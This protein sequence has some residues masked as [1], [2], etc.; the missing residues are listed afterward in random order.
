VT[1][2]LP[3]SLLSASLARSMMKGR[4]TR[5]LPI[6]LIDRFVFGI[7]PSSRASGSMMAATLLARNLTRKGAVRGIEIQTLVIG[8]CDLLELCRVRSA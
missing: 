6:S 7:G 8:S 4:R 1:K 3:P 2:Q 5:I